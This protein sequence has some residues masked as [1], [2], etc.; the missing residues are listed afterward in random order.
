MRDEDLRQVVFTIRKINNGWHVALPD[1]TQIGPYRADI[2]VEVAVAEVLLARRRGLN[3]RLFVRDKF[4]GTHSC[5]LVDWLN[6]PDRCKKCEGSWRTS[7]VPVICPL[8]ATI[9][10]Q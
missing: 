8:Q 1:E 10:T 4:G 2:A 7:A 3:A 9:S 5:M 6:D